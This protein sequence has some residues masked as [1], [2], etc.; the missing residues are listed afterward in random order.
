MAR[1]PP[2]RP[3]ISLPQIAARDPSLEEHDEVLFHENFTLDY[4]TRANQSVPFYVHFRIIT[5][6]S[7]SKSHPLEQ[8]KFEIFHD[9][10]LY[11]FVE[12]VFLASQFDEFKRTSELTVEFGEFPQEVKKLLL[13]SAGRKSEVTST[14]W[15]EEESDKPTL[16][17]TQLLDLRA[18]EIFR[19]SFQKPGPEFID[20]QAQYRYEKLAYELQCK[21]LMLSE[22]K[23]FMQSRNP[24]LMRSMAKGGKSLKESKPHD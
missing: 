19:I 18:V 10:D 13:D 1:S 15:E 8:V 14:L 3:P 2:R 12:A 16:V 9:Q 6:R 7:E 5:R 22:F 17:F 20:Q 23:R 24:V 21:R 11:F 4:R